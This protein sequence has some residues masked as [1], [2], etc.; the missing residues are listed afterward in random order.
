MDG[1]HV[2]TI[3][4]HPNRL[5][6]IPNLMRLRRQ[7]EDYI[8]Y[9]KVTNVQRGK[10]III[11]TR[12]RQANVERLPEVD[13]INGMILHEIVLAIALDVGGD[14][15]ALLDEAEPYVGCG[16][17]IVVAGGTMSFAIARLVGDAPAGHLNHG[18]RG[19]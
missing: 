10:D 12:H 17:A 6:R 4:L 14:G 18:M 8:R 2:R 13:G 5:A 1:P 19:T 16:V 15:I 3:L 11:M 9:L 7:T